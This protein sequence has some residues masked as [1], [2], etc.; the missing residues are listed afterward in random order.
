MGFARDYII[1]SIA[2]DIPMGHVNE[3][4]RKNYYI[5]MGSTQGVQEGTLLDVYRI[6]SMNDPYETKKR[7]DYRVKIG[8]LKVIHTEQNASI[9]IPGD[10]TTLNDELYVDVQNFM[11]GDRINV[12]ISK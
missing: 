11:V 12:K 3:K 1:Y 8:E 5:N 2:Q 9:G 7:Y 10:N 6:I 4:T